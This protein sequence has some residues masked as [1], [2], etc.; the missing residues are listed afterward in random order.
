M[1]VRRKQR[2]KPQQHRPPLPAELGVYSGADWGAPSLD[3][4]GPVWEAEHRAAAGRFEQARQEWFTEHKHLPA[5][6]SHAPRGD[7]PWCGEFGPHE[8]N[9]ADCREDDL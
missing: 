8:C 2:A 4:D 7:T 9:V 6:P 3:G 5:D 1:P